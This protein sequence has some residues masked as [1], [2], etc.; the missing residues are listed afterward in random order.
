MQNFTIHIWKFEMY[1][2]NMTI[3]GV[4]RMPSAELTSSQLRMK[5][6]LMMG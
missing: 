1:V 3:V 5:K 6:I 2:N 4:E